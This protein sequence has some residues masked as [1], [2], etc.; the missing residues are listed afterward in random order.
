MEDATVVL[1]PNDFAYFKNTNFQHPSGLLRF[2]VKPPAN[3]RQ[4][5]IL[6]S[7]L[8]FCGSS[9]HGANRAIDSNNRLL[10]RL[11]WLLI[12][13]GAF[14]GC[15]V[16]YWKLTGRH[17]EETLVTVVESARKP[18]HDIEFP[19]VA[20][21]PLNHINWIRNK[22]AEEKFL[23][24]NP[25]EQIIKIFHDLLA[26]ME[27]LTFITLD[28]VELLLR[29]AFVP[30]S[31]ENIILYD[32]ALHM[33]FRCDE[34]FVWCVYDET[35]LD[36]CKVFIHERTERGICLVFNSLISDESKIKQVIG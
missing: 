32:L 36:C 19:A 29:N 2:K 1:Y 23:P 14:V 6:Q 31:L 18:I 10:V 3:T 12:V 5:K 28:G 15:F 26:A 7:L 11:F 34:I 20:V 24:Q 30:K 4:I 8:K 16:M 13:V 33:A 25:T 9:L 22:S 35:Q 17:Q 21:C 27:R